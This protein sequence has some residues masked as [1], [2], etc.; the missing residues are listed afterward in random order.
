[1]GH[2]VILGV[3]CLDFL[4]AEYRHRQ[5]R[6]TPAT[7][8]QHR[9][10]PAMARVFISY[11]H[12]DEDWKNRVVKQLGVLATEG[13]EVW[14]DR[15]IAVG[16][17]WSNEIASAIATCDVAVLLISA[18]FL[19]SRFILGQEVPA[20][21][22]RRQQQGIRVVPLILTPCTWTRIP[23]LAPIQARPKDGKPLSG[24]NKHDAEAALAALAGEIADFLLP[25]PSKMSTIVPPRPPGSPPPPALAIWQEK[26]DFLRQQQAICS[27]PAQKFTLKKQIEEATAKVKEL[28]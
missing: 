8:I 19:T 9:G 18:D 26:L 4:A 20:L 14:D 16:A 2:D 5:P 28:S 7:A 17:A 15:K 23:W 3:V 25:S 12:Q 1:M 6:L 22:Q 21:L 11:S 13:L 27:D 24:M 10:K